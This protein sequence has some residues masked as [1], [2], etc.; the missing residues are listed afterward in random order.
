MVRTSNWPPLSGDVG[1]HLLAQHVL[2]E[3]DPVQLDVG[4]GLGEIVRQL[5][6]VDHIAVV[7][8]RDRQRRFGV[9]GKREACE[10]N[11]AEQPLHKNLHS[12]SSVRH[13]HLGICQASGRIFAISLGASQ[14]R[15]SPTC[16]KIQIP[17]KNPAFWAFF[18]PNSSLQQM[19]RGRLV[20][21]QAGNEPPSERSAQRRPPRRSHSDADH[22][23]VVGASQRRRGDALIRPFREH[24][25]RR[26]RTPSR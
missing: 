1:R 15:F 19:L 25:A 2:F 23:S 17:V 7:D 8:G 18:A 11:G 16:S 10:R 20:G 4:I 14:C 26:V 3:R 5:L 22:K 21:D 12:V 9:S 13:A 24:L 6:H